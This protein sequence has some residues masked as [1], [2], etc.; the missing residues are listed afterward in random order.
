[1]VL[2]LDGCSA[3]GDYAPV[4]RALLTF[5]AFT[6][7]RPGELFALDWKDIDL[8]AGRVPRRAAAVSRPDRPAQVEPRAHDRAHPSGA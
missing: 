3:L 6:L 7:M 8:D 2:L 4:M 1:M 5:A